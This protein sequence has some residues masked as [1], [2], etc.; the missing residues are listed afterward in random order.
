MTLA[1]ADLY[2]AFKA[3]TLLLLA[4]LL[5]FVGSASRSTPL[6]A[7]F[8]F[9]G[10]IGLQGLEA[11][12]PVLRG[13]DVK[14]PAQLWMLRAS[15]GLQLI[16]ASVLVAVTDGSG[17]IYELVYLLPIASAA[18]KL[19]GRDV[20]IVVAGAVAAMVGF[21][22][23]GEQLTTS[24]ARVREF[25]DAVAAI[26]YFT[27]AGVLIY[28]FAKSERDE[29][30][31]S[32]AMVSALKRT[33]AELERVRAELTERVSQLAHMEE[34]VQRISQMAAL[35]EVAGQVAHE[36]RNP[37][38]IIKGASEMLA[39]RVSD[40][41][42]QRH[43]SVL[44]EESEHLNR[45]V[46][47]ILRLAGPIR[48][49]SEQVR[50]A[51]VLRGVWQAATVAYPRSYELKLALWPE[52]LL[53]MCDP[54]LL[55]HALVNLV[56]NAF[57]AM[58]QGGVVTMT[59]RTGPNGNVL[60]MISDHGVGLAPEDLRRVGEPFFTRRPGGVGLGFSL[61]RRIITEHGGTMEIVSQVDRGT[62][63]TIALPAEIPAAAA[64]R[65]A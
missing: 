61:A 7:Y 34:R 63:I 28:F 38:G 24:I 8:A 60:I 42:I 40:P 11:W 6:S 55:H 43:I 16:L 62:T 10:I 51:S 50:L 54:G 17:S 56:Q 36:I 12:Y 58:P 33:N 59:V 65:G 18:G 44:L 15:I 30:L 64:S 27:M 26:A 20:V 52:P 49:Q 9:A 29:R 48:L 41:S 35:G 13:D 21:I 25:Q 3:G 32:E 37:L 14:A 31:R 22:V 4:G 46:E 45:A 5:L 19:P 2:R 39:A 57:Q 53:I 47:D 23:A 1:S